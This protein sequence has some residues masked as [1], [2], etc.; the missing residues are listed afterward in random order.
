MAF[1]EK[2]TKMNQSTVKTGK[3]SIDRPWM[4]YYPEVFTQ[5]KIPECT[6][7]DYL[8]KNCPGED[9][10]AIHYY[11]SDIT[12]KTFFEEVD[13]TARAL[14]AIGF[15]EGDEIPAFLR[16][17]PEFY[18]LLLAAEKIGASVLCR[19]NT[20][21]ENV[22]AVK[23]S[24]ARAIVAHTFLSQDELNAYLENS[25]VEKVVLLSP[26]RSGN[27]STMAI[28]IKR[29]LDSLYPKNRE[30]R[31]HG[32]A[33]ISWDDFLAL[34]DAY[35]G[36]VDAP[37]DIDRPLLR[38]YTSG[39]TGPSK[40]VIHSA[41]NVIG[42]LFQMSPYGAS[43]EF[44]PVWLQT[45]LPPSLVAVVISMV[46]APLSSNKLLILDPFCAVEDIDLDI[47]HYR[48]NIWPVVPQFL[49]VVIHSKRIPE[50]YD[51]SH[52]LSCGPGA[53]AY[54]NKQM[55][56]AQQFLIDHNCKTVLTVGYGSSEAG[57]NCT[58][59]YVSEKYPIKN[60]NIG[61][62][63][64]LSVLGVFKPGALG[65][66][67]YD[68]MGEV[69]RSGPGNMLGY[70]NPAATAK[71]LQRHADG[72]VWLHTGDIGYVTEDGIFYSLTRGDTRRFGGEPL[73]TF[74]MENR[75]ADA[76][77]KGID[78]EF[79]VLIPDDEHEGY[80]LPYLYVVLEEGYTVKD[81]RDQVMACLEPH[82]RPVDIIQLDE[83]PFFHFKT[84]RVGLTRELIEAR[85][86]AR[87]SVVG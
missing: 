72:K 10:V 40:Q 26:C 46:L 81:I 27:R 44:R 34:G 80:F 79:F 16:S 69:C 38:A 75:V 62:P 74:P 57:S 52:L 73:A 21:E 36:E 58:F 20:L 61:M 9:V 82:M 13:R 48:P 43:D 85:N 8:R 39:S 28:H 32:P 70:D 11:G 77:I 18:Y 49:E 1:T 3:A 50:D 12:W 51:M 60:G 83:R 71:T 37:V 87:N 6:V 55:K 47:M 59:P 54:N 25:H 19:D 7:L 5:L 64:P 24:G 45:I 23:K 2:E 15:G 31:A 22:D 33:T 56:T 35:T 53:E 78:D 86:E 17:V 4:Q 63:L 66:Q 30:D 65:E 14:R 84:N 29:S 67:G 76:D 42:I 41:R 68:A